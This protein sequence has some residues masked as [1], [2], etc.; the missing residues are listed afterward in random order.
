[1]KFSPYKF[2]GNVFRLDH[3][4]PFTLVVAPDKAVQTKALSILVN[5]SCHCFTEGYD[6]IAAHAYTHRGELR[7]FSHSRYALSFK[8]PDIIRSVSERKVLFSRET[9]YLI[10]EVIDQAGKAAHY[11]VFFDLKKASDDKHDLVMTIESAYIKEVLPK[12][13]DK[14]RFRIL[15]GKVARGLKVR[16]PH[17][18]QK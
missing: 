1:M 8:L 2:D 4:Q 16:S 12:H 6:G 11:T 7:S 3:L 13:L 18:Y 10:I 5:F 17:H 14:I 9:N 15:A